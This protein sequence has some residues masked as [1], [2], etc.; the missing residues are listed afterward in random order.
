ML[1]DKP[2][3]N[4]SSGVITFDF[5]NH[6]QISSIVAQHSVEER[7]YNITDRLNSILSVAV[8]VEPLTDAAE[9]S[10]EYLSILQTQI[11]YNAATDEENEKLQGRALFERQKRFAFLIRS[12]FEFG[13]S[14][15]RGL[16]V[17]SEALTIAALSEVDFDGI[18]AVKS[19]KTD[20][21]F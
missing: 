19:E 13:W 7:F 3:S 21:S 2:L 5:T 11:V 16:E 17:N 15:R 10:D 1:F 4:T 9:A 8:D 14:S 6:S 18:F 12:L 20:V